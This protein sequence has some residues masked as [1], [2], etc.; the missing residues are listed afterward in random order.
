MSVAKRTRR[1][2]RVFTSEPGPRWENL[3]RPKRMRY[4]LRAPPTWGEERSNPHPSLREDHAN[5]GSH[6]GQASPSFLSQAPALLP[7]S[8]SYRPHCHCLPRQVC[9][10]PTPLPLAPGNDFSHVPLVRVEAPTSLKL[11]LPGP[12]YRFLL[13][14]L[15]PRE[16]VRRAELYLPV[17]AMPACLLLTGSEARHAM[18]EAMS[19]LG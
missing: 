17:T 15:S 14:P 6:A 13:L 10:Q 18:E 3:W 16:G 2:K 7:G 8:T 4:S 1:R 11:L 12:W 19:R 5:T 9:I